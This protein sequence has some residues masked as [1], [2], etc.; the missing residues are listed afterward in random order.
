MIAGQ[1]KMLFYYISKKDIYF[2]FTKV[3]HFLKIS[4]NYHPSC[5]HN[6]QEPQGKRHPNHLNNTI[7]MTII[8]M[9]IIKMISIYISCTMIFLQIEE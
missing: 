8:K 4:M 5:I 2:G 1:Q 9:T 6:Q 7:K 3:I